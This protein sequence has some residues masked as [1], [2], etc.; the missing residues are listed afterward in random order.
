MTLYISSTH[1]DCNGW[2][3]VDSEYHLKACEQLEA[4]AKKRAVAMA[5][6]ENEPFGGVWKD[7]YLKNNQNDNNNSN[8]NNGMH[9]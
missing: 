4:N 3:V 2:A 1:P 5:L 8:D 6:A 9:N 7:S